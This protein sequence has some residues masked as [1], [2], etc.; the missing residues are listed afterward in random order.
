MS[1]TLKRSQE[2][3]ETFSL[4]EEVLVPTFEVVLCPTFLLPNHPVEKARRAKR[5]GCIV[6]WDEGQQD[7]CVREEK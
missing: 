3:G 6:L 1:V 2:P 7:P 5:Q 4:A